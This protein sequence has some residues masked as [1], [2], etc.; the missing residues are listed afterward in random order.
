MAD[1]ADAAM[2]SPSGVT[3]DSHDVAPVA[4]APVAA[5]IPERLH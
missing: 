1:L 4:L 3:D 2:E 5:P